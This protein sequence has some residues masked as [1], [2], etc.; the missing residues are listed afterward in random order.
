MVYKKR[1]LV[2]DSIKSVYKV[3]LLSISILIL[4]ENHYQYLQ[5]N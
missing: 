2:I 3:H 1:T 5:I 4:Q